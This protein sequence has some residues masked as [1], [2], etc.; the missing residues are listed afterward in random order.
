MLQSEPALLLATLDRMRGTSPTAET[1]YGAVAGCWRD[2]QWTILPVKPDGDLS[3]PRWS[4]ARAVNAAELGMAGACF[5]V[6]LGGKGTRRRPWYG[7]PSYPE[8]TSPN[9]VPVGNWTTVHEEGEVD[10]LVEGVLVRHPNQNW[11]IHVNDRHEFQSP[12]CGRTFAAIETALVE[13]IAAA[14][15]WL[16]GGAQ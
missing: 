12:R 6:I 14:N 1:H 11:D 3:D 13:A 10:E 16:A 7:D 4:E 2:Y 15:S 9:P 8:A 5:R